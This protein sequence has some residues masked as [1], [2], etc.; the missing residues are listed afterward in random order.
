LDSNPYKV[1]AKLAPF[2]KDINWLNISRHK[3]EYWIRVA[4]VYIIIAVMFLFWSLP[5]TFISAFS[6]LGKKK[7]E[8]FCC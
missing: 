5:V 1:K 2:P 8:F 3:G 7:I 4:C 6:N